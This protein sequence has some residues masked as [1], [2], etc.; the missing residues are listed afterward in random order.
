LRWESSPRNLTAARIMILSAIVVLAIHAAV[1]AP[2][3]RFYSFI[4]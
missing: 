2:M 3:F 4:L 1:T